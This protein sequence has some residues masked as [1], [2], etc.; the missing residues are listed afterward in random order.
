MKCPTKLD[1]PLDLLPLLPPNLLPPDLLPLLPPDLLL[2]GLPSLPSERGRAK[3]KGRSNR[4]IVEAV[5]EDTWI[6]ELGVSWIGELG[7]RIGSE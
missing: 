6:G 7:R 3:A 2:S 5:A 4:L 1:L